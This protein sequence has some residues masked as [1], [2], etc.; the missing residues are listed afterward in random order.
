[1]KKIITWRYHWHSLLSFRHT[2]N[3]RRQSAL[4]QLNPEYLS[5]VTR[6]QHAFLTTEACPM[7]S[8]DNRT[9]TSNV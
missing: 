4:E 9:R 8:I 5:N 3:I 7:C 6:P 2:S 1:M